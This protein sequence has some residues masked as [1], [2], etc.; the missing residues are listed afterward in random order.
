MHVPDTEGSSASIVDAVGEL[1]LRHGVPS[2]Q[3]SK[4]LAEILGLS[5]SQA[6]RKLNGGV[7]WT[8]GQV[9][10]VA[11]FFNERLDNVGLGGAGGGNATDASRATLTMGADGARY[12]CMVWIG[13]QLSTRAK[14]DFVVIAEGDGWAVIESSRCLDDA[15][16][17]RVNKL[18]IVV[19]NP[20]APTVAI[21]DDERGFADSLCDYL[22]D[23]GLRAVPFYDLAS[24]ERS[25]AERE[26]DGY[27]MD[28]ILGERT[29]ESLIKKI[30][31]SE[32]NAVPIYVLSGKVASGDVAEAEAA[33][34]IR[35][36][37]V[38]WRDKPIRMATFAAELQKTLG[39]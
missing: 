10:T 9:R 34:A 13:E 30:R 3:R 31:L 11:D 2:R 39:A 15:A 7:D 27:V 14:V 25:M 33:R 6:H 37:D 8:I 24:F 20:F 38:H 18:E 22:N 12:P 16:R 23:S 21:V 32:T 28:W 17:Y 26:Y 1:L 19:E 5:Y 29:S 35:Q 4:K 36:L